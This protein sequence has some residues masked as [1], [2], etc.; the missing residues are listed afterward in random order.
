[1]AKNNLNI[2]HLLWKL[3]FSPV[4]AEEGISFPHPFFLPYSNRRSWNEDGLA[5]SIF[6]NESALP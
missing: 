4:P 3:S 5:E 1:M 6:G 2:I